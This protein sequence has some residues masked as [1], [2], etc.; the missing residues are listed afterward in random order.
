[1]PHRK[2]HVAQEH[3]S[4]LDAVETLSSIVDI[5]FEREVDVAN[6][7]EIKEQD[8]L[9]TSHTMNWL[10]SEDRTHT[11]D[12]IKDTFHVVH[13][14]LRDFYDHELNYTSNAKVMEGV[15]T[16]MVLVG[17]AAKK[18]DRFTT[19][20]KETKEKSV[21]NLQEYR[22]LQ[23]F[24]LTRIARKIDEGIL[25]KWIL[26]LTKESMA[27]RKA[28]TELKA[29]P[30]MS[31]K[32]VFIDMESVKNDSEYE[33][34]FLRKE[35]GSRFFNPR[36]IRNIK[37]TADF[38]EKIRVRKEEDP[39]EH[40][41]V[42][43][44]HMLHVAARHIYQS[45]GA[46]LD[47]FFTEAQQSWRR[48]LVTELY[49]AVVALMMCSCSSNLL[50]NAPTKS[51]TEYF[52][53]FLH[54]LRNVYQTREY[55]RFLVYPPKKTSRVAHV[56]MDLAHNLSKALFTRVNAFQELIPVFE[57]VLHQAENLQSNE[58]QQAAIESNQLWS[59]LASDYAALTKMIKMHP[60]GPLVKVLDVLETG[61][62]HV[63]DPI[64]QF[65]M[66]SLT[67]SLFAKDLKMT[68]IHLPSPT[69]Q[70][71]INSVDILDEFKGFLR[72]YS[73]EQFKRKHLLFNFQDRTS[74]R[75]HVRSVGLEQ[76]SNQR[77]FANTLTVV[78]LAKDTDFYHQVN[79]YHED[80]RAEL[81]FEH[82]KENLDDENCGFYF[83]MEVK[84]ILFPNLIDSLMNSIHELFFQGM[85]VLSVKNRLDF[86]EIFYLILQLKIMEINQ[87]D[88]F[89]MTC[90]DGIDI[91][92]CAS[93]QLFVF[94]KLIH[95]K[96]MNEHDFVEFSASL[97]LPAL[98]ARERIVQPER[99]GRMLTALKR[100]ETT[101]YDMGEK[102][103]DQ[104][105]KEKIGSLFNTPILE[106]DAVFP[107]R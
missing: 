54:F 24:Y 11:I 88:T 53:D 90:K 35:D 15:K 23:E 3:L 41:N 70:G 39:F 97:Y 44:D 16:I 32:H 46:L 34:F 58:H 6:D 64:G 105:F 101:I 75:E 74:W 4:I 26:E 95:F 50:A 79:P 102:S 14:Y 42:W 28:V 20:F 43:Q 8:S 63:F 93:A 76:I 96:T 17:E 25:G 94:M 37:L 80:H 13:D 27:K 10:E 92:G 52:V 65:N 51:C 81:F 60:N 7:E 69:R 59:R 107:A 78:S 66:P 85:N 5:D 47:R 21:K 87:P 9:V 103:F 30:L 91:G 36:L 67:Y 71:F 62:Y 83:P 73:R 29:K 99:F 38:G 18:L 100:V 57:R 77:L 40:V 68:N 72:S 55:Q 49:K 48:E 84:S 82:F 33:L 89:S 86:I 12:H 19:L 61:S 31:V 45:Q 22:D 56:L 104:A 106:A 1:M 98:I 2:S